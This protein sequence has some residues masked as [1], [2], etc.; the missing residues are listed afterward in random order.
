MHEVADSMRL[1]PVL[2]STV[3]GSGEKR[4][5]KTVRLDRDFTMEIRSAVQDVVNRNLM[6]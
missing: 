1:K 2:K 4:K 5:N 6:E 3:S